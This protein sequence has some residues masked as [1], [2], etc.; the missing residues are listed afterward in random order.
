MV[1]LAYLLATFAGAQV[2]RWWSRRHNRESELAWIGLAVL[3]LLP[4]LTADSRVPL[5]LVLRVFLGVMPSSG[6]IGFL[7]PM[8]VD[9]TSAGDPDRAGRAYAVNVL[10]CI[11][12]PLLSGFILLPLVG[13]HVSMLLFV[14]PWLVMVLRPRDTGERQ[15][16]PRAAAFGLVIAALAVFFSTKSYETQ[17]T[18][19]EVRRDYT[20]TV[21][22]TG[23][24]MKKHLL[25]NGTSMTSLDQVT[26]MMA[27]LTL[28]SLY[29]PPRNVLAIC[30]GIGTTYRS[31]I[32]WGAP[33]TVA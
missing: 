3:G 10:G 20:A 4:L 25:V 11:L 33:A 12:G 23:E 29:Q 6:V 19:R 9:R 5:H 22:A 27:H 2:Y 18:H 1:L 14:L 13:E 31:V 30:F 28:S 32:S 21:I 17:F 16:A 24:G 7:T 15:L 26:K 8:L